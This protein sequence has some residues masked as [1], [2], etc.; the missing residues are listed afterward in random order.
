MPDRTLTRR[1]N[2]NA[3][4]NANTNANANAIANTN[5]DANANANATT[6]S[7]KHSNCSQTNIATYCPFGQSMHVVAAGVDT[8]FP[9]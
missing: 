8:N 1:D 7:V 6:L 3:N 9:F 5:A 4:A 2:A